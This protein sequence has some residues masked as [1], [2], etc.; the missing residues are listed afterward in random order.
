[1]LSPHYSAKIPSREPLALK[2][3]PR[4]LKWT[5][6]S[7]F[8]H[9]SRRSYPVESLALLQ[10]GQQAS[11]SHVRRKACTQSE[12]GRMQNFPRVWKVQINQSITRLLSPFIH[13]PALPPPFSIPHWALY[14]PAEMARFPTRTP[15]TH[16]LVLQFMHFPLGR[17]FLLRETA[18]M[19]L[20]DVA[21]E[22]KT[23]TRRGRGKLLRSRVIKTLEKRLTSSF[24][25]PVVWSCRQSC[26]S[27]TSIIAA[28]SFFPGSYAECKSDVVIAILRHGRDGGE[29]AS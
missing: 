10:K 6:L 17:A 18:C 23:S 5:A 8:S 11:R 2:C 4:Q 29:G 24:S 28:R 16:F 26:S 13:P 14:L 3:S 27:E 1:M 22:T 21:V 25:F 7:K 20:F 9:F 15:P 12:E 19:K